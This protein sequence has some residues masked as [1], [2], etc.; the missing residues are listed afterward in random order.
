M[1]KRDKSLVP[2]IVLIAV[3]LLFLLHQMDVFYFRWRYIYPLGL[4]ALGAVCLVSVFSKNQRSAAFPAGMF[5]S[6]GLFFFLRNYR[7]LP[8]EDYFYYPDELWP[9]FMIACGLGFIALYFAKRED[10]AVLIPGGVLVF[11]GLLFVLRTQRIIRWVD[12]RDF[13]PVILIAIGL[14]IVVHSLRKKPKQV[15][16]VGN[17]AE[18][19]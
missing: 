9:I 14:S 3:G 6:L 19:P 10:W 5:L 15:T 2:G 11:L 1:E 7:Y 8:L 4:L 13:W 12:F 16:E 17:Q 18:A